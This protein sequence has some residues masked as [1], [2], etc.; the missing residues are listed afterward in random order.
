MSTGTSLKK[1]NIVFLGNFTYPR[2]MAVTQ[3]VHLLIRGL[4]ACSDGSVRVVVLRQSSDVNVLSGVHNGVPYETVMGNL[5]RA[6]AVLLAPLFYRRATQTI[7]R[8]FQSGQTNILFVYAPPSLEILPVAR[9]ARHLGY[10]VVFYVVEDHDLARSIMTN[11]WQRIDCFLV[12]KGT[13][14]VS[15]LADAVLVISSHLEAKFRALTRD[16]LPVY[17]QPI[18]V[19]MDRFPDVPRRSVGPTTLFYSG[20]FGLKDGVPVLLDAFDRLAARNTNVRLVLTGRGSDEAMRRVL[21]RID[22]SP[23]RDRISYRG[24]LEDDAYYAA[25]KGASI[26]CMTR[27]DIGYANAGFPFKLGEYLATGKPV[28]ASRVSD[29]DR[30]LTDRHDAMLVKPGDSAEIVNAVQYLIANRDK[31]VTIGQRGRDLAASLFDYRVQGQALFA[32]LS[33]LGN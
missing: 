31:A 17:H 3:H 6:K 11:R 23:Y 28:I 12:R 15:S 2:G 1:T 5:S 26:P 30:L 24:Y 18:T 4:R 16:S 10:R 22:A 7:G 8:L 9:H 14:K 20:S 27:I 29:V 25:L 19:D 33:G 32:F 13:R 21:P